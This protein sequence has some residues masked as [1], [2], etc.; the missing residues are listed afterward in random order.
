MIIRLL[1]GEVRAASIMGWAVGPSFK[2]QASNF[3]FC[4]RSGVLGMTTVSMPNCRKQSAS[5]AR[6]GSLRSTRAARAAAFLPA[7]RGATAV[8]MA[9][10]IG[11]ID[12]Y[13]GLLILPGAPIVAR[14]SRLGKRLEGQSLSTKVLLPRMSRRAAF[15]TC[16]IH[17]LLLG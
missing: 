11:D 10:S 17:R 16:Q 13:L 6:T 5:T 3:S 12:L 8:P 2:T 15:G 7:G 14:I 1:D 9:F 4:R